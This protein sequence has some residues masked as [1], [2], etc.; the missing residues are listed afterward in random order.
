MIKPSEDYFMIF[1]SGSVFEPEDFDEAVD[2]VSAY[3]GARPSVHVFCEAECSEQ[4]FFIITM[5][6]REEA[7]ELYLKLIE[8]GDQE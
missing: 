1:S 8:E 3:H 7:R 6:S 4:V 2:A 5:K